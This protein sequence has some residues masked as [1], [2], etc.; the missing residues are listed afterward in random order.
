MP[1]TIAVAPFGSVPTAKIAGARADAMQAILD[2]VVA[3]G[4]PDVIAAIITPAGTWTGAAGVGGP[5]GRK[6]TVRDEFAIASVTKTITASLVMRLA[7]QGKID[8]DA[9][10]QTYLGTIKANANGATVRQ[11]LGQRSG[12]ADWVDAP[13]LIKADPAHHW[14]QAELLGRLPPP[15]TEPG[16]GY[17]QAGPNYFLLGLAIEHVTGLSLSD[18]LRTEVLDPVG[19]TRIVQQANGVATPK[20]WALPTATHTGAFTVKDLGAGGAISCISSASFGPG[21]GS[22]ASD[23]PSLAAWAWHLFAGDIVKRESLMAM[24]PALSDGHGLAIDSLL[25]PLDRAVGLTGGKTGYGTVL[26]VDPAARTIAVVLVNDEN[27]R[28]DDYIAKLMDAANAG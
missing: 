14:T 18:A 28:I 11:V 12:L 7:E 24:L 8:L 3:D 16:I 15:S 26:A 17:A 23:A 10:L 5:D 2:S 13:R 22:I 9:P 19:A 1:S 6:A 4:A 21:A 25:A 20:P 27:F